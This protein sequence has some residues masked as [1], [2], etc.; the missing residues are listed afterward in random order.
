MA[1]D[2]KLREAII[3]L[4]FA[5]DLET[6]RERE[7]RYEKLLFKLYEHQDGVDAVHYFKQVIAYLKPFSHSSDTVSA[8]L[9]KYS[10][11]LNEGDHADTDIY[12]SSWERFKALQITKKEEA[13]KLE[14]RK[15]HKKR[16][17]TK[18]LR[19]HSALNYTSEYTNCILIAGE[20]KRRTQ[21]RIHLEI[22][23]KECP[24]LANEL[25]RLF[26]EPTP[27][28]YEDTAGNPAAIDF[29]C[30]WIYGAP[31]EIPLNSD[32]VGDLC[33][34]IFRSLQ[35]ANQF[36]LPALVGEIISELGKSFKEHYWPSSITNSLA[37]A[38]EYQAHW[39]YATPSITQEQIA[40]F[41]NN[42]YFEGEIQEVQDLLQSYERGFIAA[43]PGNSK[44][45]QD[46]SVALCM[47]MNEH[48]VRE[49]EGAEQAETEEEEEGSLM[50]NAVVIDGADIP[51][52]LGR[53]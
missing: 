28:V 53:R 11:T 2:T 47:I 19:L 1:D 34:F 20:G 44:F 49:A 21:F 12:Q 10:G 6:T 26:P 27:R 7:E 5:T 32:E 50:E 45:Y 4:P 15:S 36:E 22:L 38:Y 40:D 48:C 13:G 16:G 41:I 18:R 8:F 51:T 46:M 31:F 39:G 35:V 9:K 14:R 30:S 29:V 33:D 52:V 37:L 25:I 24:Y 42:T 3:E 43:A 17:Y 23:Q